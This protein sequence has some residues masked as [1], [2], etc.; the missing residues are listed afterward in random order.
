MTSRT[1]RRFALAGLAALLLLP[2]CGKKEQ[3]PPQA[4]TQETTSTV[5]T[6]TTL[7]PPPTTMPTPPPVWRSARWGMTKRE[8]LAAFPGEAQP[9]AQPA[10]FA[11]P[12]PGSS[13]P[14]GSSNVAI[15]AY[16]A[17]GTMFRVL[18]GFESDALNRVHM[19]AVKPA[20]STCDDVE[21]LLTE[22]HSAPSQRS[23]TGSS[24]KGEEMIWKRP[25]QT[26]TLAC[27][28]VARLG[29]LT[30]TLDYMAPTRE[31]AEEPAGGESRA[32]LPPKRE[33]TP[34]PYHDPGMR[35]R[36]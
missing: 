10:A 23:R 28:G 26:I 27:A 3:P 30:V 2:S 6:T 5:A 17:D 9:L 12:Q 18:F 29:F 14:M 16:Q 32:P 31:A 1:R 21:K 34:S 4:R 7:P 22:K 25:D 11:Q 35:V 8:V 15:P 19:S 33:T 36:R 20:A 24:L 13:I